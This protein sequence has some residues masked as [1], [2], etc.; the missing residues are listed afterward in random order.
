MALSTNKRVLSSSSTQHDVFLSFRGE[1]TRNNFISYLNG[2]LHE[3]DI[4]TF[5]DDE[6]QRG[7]KI[8]TE[9]LEA[10]ESSK[11]LIIVFSKNYATSTWCLD[12]LIKILECEKKD[13]VVFPV[14]YDVDPS[15][16]RN[17]KGKFGE[18][19]AKHE[20]SF[21]HDTDKVQRW[22]AALN[23]AGNLSGWHYKNDLPLFPFIQKIYEEVSA[24]LKFSQ[25]FVAKYL[26]G[27]DSR[28]EEISGCLDIES[29]DVRMLVIHGLPGIGKTTIAK[30]TFNFIARHF[31]GRS[32]LENVRE[33]SKTNDGVLKL[34][35]ELYYEIS[36]GRNLKV[37]GVSK[38]IN[39]IMERLHHK[40]ILLILDDVD[41][42]VQV[43]NLLGKC[44]WFASGS[45]IIITTREKQLLS[46]LRE[47]CHLF[48][49]KV[50]ELDER[51]SCEL[52][53][54]YAFKR[55]KAIEDYSELVHQFIGYAKGLPLVL[56][57][58]GADLYDKDVQYWKSA[59]DKSKRIPHLD[60]Q[61]VLKISYDGLDQI[62][63]NIFLDIAFFLKG[64]HKNLVVDILQSSNSHNPYCD[65]EKLINKS[66]IDVAKD[67]HLLMHDLIQQMGFEINRQ[68]AEV[69]NK[70][71]RLSCYEDALDVLNGD[72][73]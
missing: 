63:Q 56:K 24:K 15:E 51:E 47:D 30:A 59:L 12:E 8:S 37:H 2:F 44:N 42:V 45:R 9:L 53:C 41:K 55:N 40:K 18:V 33:N 25:L 20:E 19:L 5:M 73:V 34:Q 65:F 3:K 21:K 13:Q 1:D 68:E 49:Y 32:F 35:E 71:R 6:L 36:R 54:K 72:T 64:F 66:L 28:V 29:N 70:R 48:Y 26:V 4:N 16:V 23:K 17:Q 61:E 62:Q 43:E 52:F 22:R 46:T 10:I 69:S 58:I 11:I 7:E 60:I 39:E 38:R 31:E 27:L 57:I 67:G 50:K 14:F